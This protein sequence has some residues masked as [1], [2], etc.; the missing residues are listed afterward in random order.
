LHGT[1][2]ISLHDVVILFQFLW[3][4]HNILW[5][6]ISKQG[7]MDSCEGSH[8]ISRSGIVRANP[9]A[10]VC[11]FPFLFVFLLLNR[12]IYQ[13]CF[14][15]HTSCHLL[16]LM[17]N[18][19]L[20]ERS[21]LMVGWKNADVERNNMD[22]EWATWYVIVSPNEVWKILNGKFYFDIVFLICHFICICDCILM[23]YFLYSL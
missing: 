17:S 3:V 11:K 18:M 1:I 23:S 2:I 20:L 13:F 5:F 10:V 6:A 9:A 7:I 16:R 21:C 8:Y 4:K 15:I 22:L 14:W 19:N 12:P